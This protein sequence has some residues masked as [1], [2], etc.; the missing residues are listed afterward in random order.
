MKTLI[1]LSLV[2]CAP[3][4]VAS[5]AHAADPDPFG[6]PK[7]QSGLWKES[8][9]FGW[10]VD[11]Q[12]PFVYHL[13]HEWT[14]AYPSGDWVWLWDYALNEWFATGGGVYPMLYE[15]AADAWMWYFKGSKGPRWYQDVKS[16]EYYLEFEGVL[17]PQLMKEAFEG[18]LALTGQT[19]GTDPTAALEEVMGLALLPI[20]GDPATL[21]CPVITRTPE[22]IDLFGELPPE[23]TAFADF[24]D[25]CSPGENIGIV[26]GTMNIGIT[27]FILGETGASANIEV[28]ADNLTIDGLLAMDGSMS[29]EFS[30]DIAEEET[31]SETAW[32]TTTTTGISLSAAFDELRTADQT[33][34]GTISLEGTT[35]TVEEEDFETYEETE[36][37]S[38]ELVL[39]FE[40]LTSD[41]IDVTSGTL[42]MNLDMPGTSSFAMDME[43]PDGPILMTLLIEE[44]ED[45]SSVVV[46]TDGV[47]TFMDYSLLIEDLEFDDTQCEDYPIGGTITIGMGDS[48]QYLIRIK[49]DCTGGYVIT[50][51]G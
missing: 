11:A 17:M 43:T 32:I 29:A 34:G 26:A 47:G 48:A 41:L 4:L 2:L 10:Y 31:E 8:E 13:E 23:I 9:W 30:M 18:A 33:L 7:Q 46:Y 12:F 51:G 42:T 1:R 50:R 37:T 19:E 27:N 20:L 38:G 22:E 49:D 28:I 14:Y 40:N 39:T 44:S 5:F 6:P 3:A 24:G 15:P 21:E 45:G 25:G 35:V 16:S 36:S